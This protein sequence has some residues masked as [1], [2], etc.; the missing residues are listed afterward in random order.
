MAIIVASA[1]DFCHLFCSISSFNITGNSTT[2][3]FFPILPSSCTPA[4]NPCCGYIES[5]YLVHEIAYTQTQ[6]GATAGDGDDDDDYNQ[7][8]SFS[9]G[10]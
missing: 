2:Y 8:H 10:H 1:F 3:S 5:V 7:K 9:R 6:H 4:T